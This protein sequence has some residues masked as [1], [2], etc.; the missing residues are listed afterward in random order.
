MGKSLPTLTPG[1]R[2]PTKT[3]FA[4]ET[5]SVSDLSNAI[6]SQNFPS[7]FATAMIQNETN[8]FQAKFLFR[9]A[10]DLKFIEI[11]Q[12]GFP[13]K[14]NRVLEKRVESY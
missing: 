10:Q 7:K 9:R 1:A 14:Y 2:A 3:A 6:P 4:V 12:L 13:N 5:S 8:G 11:I